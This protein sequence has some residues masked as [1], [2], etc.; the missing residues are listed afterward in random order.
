MTG[1][2][3]LVDGILLKDCVTH[4][5]T[6]GKRSVN[7]ISYADIVMLIKLYGDNGYLEYL[8]NIVIAIVIIFCLYF[9]YELYLKE[10]TKWKNKNNNQRE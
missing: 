5:T 7:K 8:S 9:I 6:N 4:T 2:I 10:A 3:L 1:R